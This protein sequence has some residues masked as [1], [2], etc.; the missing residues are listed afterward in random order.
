[1]LGKEGKYKLH[2]CFFKYK[3]ISA[4]AR[5]CEPFL[6]KS[7][8]HGEKQGPFDGF[9]QFPPAFFALTSCGI[10]V[11]I[12]LYKKHKGDRSAHL[13]VSSAHRG[14]AYMLARHAMRAGGSCVFYGHSKSF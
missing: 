6:S 4:P 14:R 10:C 13:R 8:Q 9:L 5:V 1:M 11:N 3:Q 12:F 7:F 2:G